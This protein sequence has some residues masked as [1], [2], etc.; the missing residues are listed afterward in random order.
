MKKF[1]VIFCS[2]TL[3]ATLSVF[4][5]NSGKGPAKQN[6]GITELTQP[7]N[8]SI[9]KRGKYLLHQSGFNEQDVEAISVYLNHR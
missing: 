5:Y 7:V 1:L 6:D 2:V 4:A 9:F 8:D 3:V